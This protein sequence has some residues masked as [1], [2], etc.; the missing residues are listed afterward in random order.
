MF[1][2]KKKN[3]QVDVGILDEMSVISF[4]DRDVSLVQKVTDPDFFVTNRDLL[5][6]LGTTLEL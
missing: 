4:F 2:I 1:R 5:R 6:L 3:I